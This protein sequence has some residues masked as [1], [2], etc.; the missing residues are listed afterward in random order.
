MFEKEIKFIS[1]FNLN[2][3]KKLGA[4]FTLDKL[5]NSDL[6]PAVIKYISAELDFLIE[7]DRKKILQQ[8]VF[9]YSGAD[10]SKYFSLIG[11]EIKK[12]KRVSFE[13]VKKLI[14]QAVSFNVNYTARPRWSLTKLVYDNQDIKSVE[15][16]KL[17][18]NYLYYYDYLRTILLEYF[19]KKKMQSLNALDFELLLNKIDKNLFYSQTDKLLENAISS[20]AH[21]HNY[22][23][24]S[25]S[26]INV[27]TLEIFLKEKALINH[28]IKLRSAVPADANQKIEI[29][30]LKNMLYGIEPESKAPVPITADDEEEQEPFEDLSEI[31][32]DF[33]KEDAD[34][35]EEELDSESDLLRTE[36][37]D[38]KLELLE[39]EPEISEDD[40]EIDDIEKLEPDE[41]DDSLIIEKQADQKAEASKP[42]GRYAFE[43]TEKISFEK[44][45][46]ESKKDNPDDEFDLPDKDEDLLSF[47]DKQLK[48]FEEENLDIKD[49]KDEL[50]FD[51]TEKDHLDTLYEFEENKPDKDHEK[52]DFIEDVIDEL[53]ESDDF[54]IEEEAEI[55][56]FDE[57]A[58]EVTDDEE[59]LMEAN[60][61]DEIEA[62][63][64]ASA[65]NKDLF[66]YISN[67]D[68]ERI[69]GNVFNDDRDDFANTMERISECGNY[70]EATE[71]LKSVFLTYRINP[72]N[73][74]AVTLTNAVSNYF[75]Q[76]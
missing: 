37:D 32:N 55:K 54:K 20:I 70:D 74:D 58:D 7:E 10:V 18:L 56:S 61:D 51:M 50:E 75:D 31:D 28:L 47:Y 48:S 21:F 12:S 57:D 33:L 2:K 66:S 3:I 26:K 8:S 15:E 40:F 68:M 69:V 45:K 5:F 14:V 42:S 23:S 30:E 71:I 27:N 29:E 1:D 9:D 72:Y 63:T 19:S 64:P 62:E 65:R 46:E 60:T 22:G 16:I 6:H 38:D 73:R 39:D 43:E 4:F 11:N 24:A 41:E 25:T 13:D 35:L 59:A 44:E 17:M 52:E 36:L 67:K 76:A 34:I 53:Q 49:D